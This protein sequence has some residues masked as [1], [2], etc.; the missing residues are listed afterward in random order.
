M[1]FVARMA[2]K[3]DFHGR[4]SRSCS[5]SCKSASNLVKIENRSHKRSHKLD[6]IGVRRIRMFPF[7]S[8]SAYDSDVYDPM[9]TRLSES[10]AEAEEPTHHNAGFILWLPVTTPTI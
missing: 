4:R 9:K 2:V 7:S 8:N 10:Q 1:H 5:Q 3:A 6:R